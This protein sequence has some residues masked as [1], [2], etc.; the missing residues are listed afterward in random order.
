MSIDPNTMEAMEA[1]AFRRLLDHLRSH[2]SE[3][4]GVP[5]HVFVDLGLVH[6][7]HCDLYE[8]RDVTLEAFYD[9]THPPTTYFRGFAKSGFH[10]CCGVGGG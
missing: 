7:G 6:G 3:G 10:T 8:L 2:H 1:A 5:L 4:C 9:S